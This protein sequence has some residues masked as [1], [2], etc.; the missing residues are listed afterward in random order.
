[1]T[2]LVRAAAWFGILGAAAAVGADLVLQYTPDASH[3]GAPSYAY[4]LDVSRARLLVG[5]FVGVPAILLEI[6]GFCFVG[7]GLRVASGRVANVFIAVSAVAYAFGAAFHAMFAAIG[8]ALQSSAAAGSDAAALASLAA[9]LRSAHA[10]LGAVT[11]LGIAG[12]SILCSIR[13]ARGGTAFPRWFAVCSPLVI[14]I[15]LAIAARLVPSLRLVLLPAGLNLANLLFFAIAAV[16]YQRQVGRTSTDVKQQA[17]F[18][19]ERHTPFSV[20]PP[21]R[22]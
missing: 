3:V 13:V 18:E 16:S 22:R 11:L 6:A 5:E 15:G 8:V 17:P 10:G 20:F 14:A 19:I 1:M 9:S 2:R 4:L 21:F 12:S 7:E